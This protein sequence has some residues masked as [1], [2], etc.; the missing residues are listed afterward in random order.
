MPIELIDRDDSSPLIPED[1]AS[2]ILGT[3]AEESVVMR[4]GRRLPNMSRRQR[5]Q[6]VWSVLPQAFFVNGDTGLKQTTVTAWENVF[7]DAE[8]IA[9]FVVIP[10]AVADDADYD[11]L[12][13][14]K[15]GIVS[16]IGKAFDQAVLYGINAPTSWPDPITIGAD[17]AGHNVTAGDVGDLYDDLMG[18]GGVL[19]LIEEDGFMPNGHVAALRMKAKLRGLREKDVDG[20]ATGQPIFVSSRMSGEPTEYSLDGEPLVFP[21]N[22]AIDPT[23]SLL[24]SGDW[25][26]LVW[27]V[28]QD[29]TYKVITEGVITDAD[30]NIL[31]NLPQQDSSALR[32]VFRVGWA[33]PNPINLVNE[34]ESTRYPFATYEPVGAS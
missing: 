5:R 11:I 22:G 15:P 8:E 18:E 6:P 30:N 12:Q 33:L 4:F 9:C 17:E 13:E 3:I 28:R 29:L 32:V 25:S 21:R 34:D 27:A 14:V 24:V 2:E 16:A 20:N 19:S 31:I 23:R 1:V 7:I 10:D 26:Q